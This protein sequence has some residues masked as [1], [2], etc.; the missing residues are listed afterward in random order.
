ML[1]QA[2]SHL[3][4]ASN[5]KYKEFIDPACVSHLTP[6]EHAKVIGLVGKKCM[7]KCLF[8]DSEFDTL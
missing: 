4:E 3:S 7:V 8:N 2:I 6:S 5:S 1:C